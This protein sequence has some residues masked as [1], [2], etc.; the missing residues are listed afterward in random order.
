[1]LFWLSANQILST[2]AYAEM[3]KIMIIMK[4]KST[5]QKNKLLVLFTRAK[6]HFAQC[7]SVLPL[8][9]VSSTSVCCLLQHQIFTL[10]FHRSEISGPQRFNT[11]ISL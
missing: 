11:S 10:Q 2:Q 7:Q 8:G 5:V 3:I 4:W 9:S 6:H 1:M